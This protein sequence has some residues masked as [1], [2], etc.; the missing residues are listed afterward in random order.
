MKLKLEDIYKTP[1]SV[2]VITTYLPMAL[3]AVG[4]CF[5]SKKYRCRKYSSNFNLSGTDYVSCRQ[6]RAMWFVY[7]TTKWI[8]SVMDS[9]WTE[10]V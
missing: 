10:S 7:M 4:M 6:L 3:L 8:Y 9:V 2:S 1:H 5:L